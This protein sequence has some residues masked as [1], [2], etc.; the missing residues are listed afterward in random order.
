M[1]G[2]G[3]LLNADEADFARFLY[4]SLLRLTEPPAGGSG[5]EEEGRA[6]DSS[7]H[8]ALAAKTVAALLLRRREY[9][10]ERVA[11]FALRLLQVRHFMA[12]LRAGRVAACLS[13]AAFPAHCSP[14]V[15]LS[16]PA[17]ATLSLVAVSRALLAR[18][19]AAAAVLAPPSELVR[20]GRA[21]ALDAFLRAAAHDTSQQQQQQGKQKHGK[22]AS[23]AAAKA[24]AAPSA[25]SSGSAQAA[26]ATGVSPAERAFLFDC[27]RSGSL[28]QTAWPLAALLSHFHPKVGR[29]SPPRRLLL[30]PRLETPHCTRPP[31]GRLHC[32]RIPPPGAP[33]PG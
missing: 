17:H 15:A 1:D 5:G 7:A 19:P 22:H 10:V 27:D 23:S 33:P 29:R 32:R 16:L 13:G 25:L 11:A 21:S 14:Q 26:A 2:P 9:S 30:F 31:T 4:A 6:A 18:Y 20:G 8:A 24:A 3:E 12:F 28:S